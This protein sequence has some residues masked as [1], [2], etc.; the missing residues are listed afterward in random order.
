M[1]KSAYR[2]QQLH[3]IETKWFKTHVATIFAAESDNGP[4]WLRWAKPGT[5]VFR[6][7]YLI[8]RNN[9][10]VSGDIG[11][12]SFCWSEQISLASLASFDWHYFLGKAQ[13]IDGYVEHLEWCHEHAGE[14]IREAIDDDK[15]L[16][17]SL[18]EDW[19]DRLN[20][21]DEWQGFLNS[22]YESCDM[23]GEDLSRL[24]EAGQCWNMRALAHW[25]GL[26]MA[27]AQL[28]LTPLRQ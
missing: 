7:D 25:K 26:Q 10:H 24:L 5:N 12:T 11:H 16:I 21:K 3:E 9:L 1:K 27:H 6:V 23:D 13:G 20:S 22:C 18:G 28:N 19:T 15:I 17:K 8:H 14:W 2:E 4:V